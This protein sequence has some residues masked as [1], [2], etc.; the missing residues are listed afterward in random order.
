VGKRVQAPE[1]FIVV[2]QK[3]CTGC[4]SCTVICGGQV[5]E[6]KEDKAYVLHIDQCL[7][8]WSCEV[9]CDA[10]A[11]QVQ[12]PASGTGVIYSCG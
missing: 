1:R 9:V 3:K 10:G 6:I 8:C 5:F 7:E 11:I 12:V 2:N 4:G